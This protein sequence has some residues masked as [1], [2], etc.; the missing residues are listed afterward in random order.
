[1]AAG[2]YNFVIEQG[3]SVNFTVNYKDASNNPIDF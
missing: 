1:M 3:S 2:K